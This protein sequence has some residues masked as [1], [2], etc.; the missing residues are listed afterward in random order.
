[1]DVFIVN[2]GVTGFVAANENDFAARTAALLKDAALRKQMSAAA[3]QQAQGESWDAVFEKAY[4]GYRIACN[5]ANS[6]V[7]TT[8]SLNG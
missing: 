3:R 1:M 8:A 2:P 4:D 6:G 5:R 7:S